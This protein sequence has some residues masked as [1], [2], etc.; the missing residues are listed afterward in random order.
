MHTVDARVLGVHRDS[1]LALIRVDESGLPELRFG[2]SDPGVIEAIRT[3]HQAAQD[4]KAV[5]GK[6][7][8]RPPTRRYRR[9]SDKGIRPAA[10]PRTVALWGPQGLAA[11][12]LPASTKE[13][14]RRNPACR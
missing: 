14:T 7:V 8:R 4:R 6:P 10:R 11:A 13:D 12:R 2:H 5:H 1:D 3:A 9:Q